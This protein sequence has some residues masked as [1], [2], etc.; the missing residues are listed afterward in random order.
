MG[1]LNFRPRGY[2]SS[3]FARDILENVPDFV[4]FNQNFLKMWSLTHSQKTPKGGKP[5][6]YKICIYKCFHFSPLGHFTL[7]TH[8]CSK[9]FPKLFSRYFQRQKFWVE[10]IFCPKLGGWTPPRRINPSNCVWN[11]ILINKSNQSEA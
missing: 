7:K 8:D 9:K 1:N 11:L 4:E 3:V 6:F 5:M 10:P 2:S